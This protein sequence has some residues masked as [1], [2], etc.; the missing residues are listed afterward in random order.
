M[1]LENNT[2]WIN[3]LAGQIAGQMGGTSNQSNHNDELLQRIIDILLRILDALLNN[4]GE[5]V[6][7]IGETEL[8]RA[9]IK[10]INNV[11]RQSGKT[12]LEV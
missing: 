2:G 1:P 11:Q 3:N 12:L 8:G 10:A 9:T 6:L 7:K 4:D 5:T